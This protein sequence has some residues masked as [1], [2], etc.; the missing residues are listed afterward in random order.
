MSH[1]NQ[2][3]IN[4]FQELNDSEALAIEGG[5][6]WVAVA[7]SIVAYELCQFADGFYDGLMGR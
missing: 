5:G 3:D 7:A 4:G 2:L 1:V 6:F